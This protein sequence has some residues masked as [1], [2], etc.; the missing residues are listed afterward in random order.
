[1]AGECQCT[2]GK[3]GL[4]NMQINGRNQ[5]TLEPME[6]QKPVKGS[7]FLTDKGYPIVHGSSFLMALEFTASGPRGKAFLTYS[8]SGD[9]TSP[10][11][12]DQTELFAKKQWRPVLFL[13]KDVI[14]DTKRAYK[15]SNRK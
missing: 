14:A 8:E 4:M 13:E 9:P 7:P 11:Y 1:M 10:H 6:D 15:V 5:T 2:G 3:D 12:S